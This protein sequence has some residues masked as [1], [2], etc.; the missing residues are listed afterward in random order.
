MGVNNAGV[1][2]FAGAPL[3]VYPAA[4]GRVFYVGSVAVPGGV[5]GTDNAGAAGDTPKYPFATLAYA[6]SQCTAGRGDVVYV[7][8]GHTES[9]ISATAFT[10]SVSGVKFIGLGEGS[11][12]PTIT[13]TTANTAR[14][15]ITANDVSFENMI[16]VGNFLSIATC[17][18]ISGAS[19]CKISGN[20]FRDTSAILNFLSIVTTIVSTTTDGLTITGNTVY[21]DGTTS[22]G[23]VVVIAN[24]ISNL[25]ITDNY[26][27]MSVAQNNVAR[28]LAHAALVVTHGIVARNK[29][30]T[31][32]SDTATGGAL[33]TTSATTGSGIMH[34]NYVAS[35]DTTA[36]IMV[37]A[38]A[39]Q[40][41]SFAN[42]H[43]GDA[44]Q[45]S[46]FLLPAIGSD[47]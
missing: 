7:L 5:A 34:D 14:I 24:T 37:T 39:V 23:P 4:T 3:L 30:L 18:R 13:F 31:A 43:I 29:I 2:L 1:N 20:V 10:A 45:L 11:L 19:N 6:S 36:A 17:F 8:P 42:L 28:L 40:W 15:N 22:G 12:R 9:I 33:I 38:T 41:K 35:E 16:F 32:N 44:T 46:G 21:Q 27:F 47:A 26:A 25:T